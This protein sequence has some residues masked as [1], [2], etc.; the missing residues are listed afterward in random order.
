VLDSK[1][2]TEKGGINLADKIR[3]FKVQNDPGNQEIREK[4]LIERSRIEGT[5]VF[6]E[7][8]ADRL[9]WNQ[10]S[11]A[12]QDTVIQG[13]E[14][15]LGAAFAWVETQSYSC[16]QATHRIATF[17]HIETNIGLNLVPGGQ[18]VRGTRDM[19]A[20]LDF[21]KRFYPT[22]DIDFFGLEKPRSVTVA[23]MLMGRFPV[24]Y[25][26][27]SKVQRRRKDQ[28]WKGANFPI[29]NIAWERTQDWLRQVGDGLRLPWERE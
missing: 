29:E 6:R 18:Y 20:E 4:R 12:F 16:Q 23:P 17:C 2:P 13:V 11:H 7:I 26:Q 14:Q 22:R 3:E 15:Q 21:V 24:T 19:E 10:C 1:T 25:A 9:Q 27:W 5:R 28:E 8:L